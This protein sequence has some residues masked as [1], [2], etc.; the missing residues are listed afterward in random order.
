MQKEA[1][2]YLGRWEIT[3]MDMWAKSYIDLLGTGFIEFD[4]EEGGEFRFGTVHGWLLFVIEQF[5]G[6]ERL[7]FSWDGRS[8]TDP[9]CGRGWVKLKGGEL[10]GRLFIHGS[11]DSHFK[12]RAMPAKKG[13]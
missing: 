4:A 6:E 10:H 9:G 1:K 5:G 7:E 11:D 13:K 2:P 8:D 12:A 3:E